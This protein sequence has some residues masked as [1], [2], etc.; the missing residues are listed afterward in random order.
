MSGFRLV[1]SNSEANDIENWDYTTISVSYGDLLEMD[2]GATLAT[3]GDSSTEA[4]QR[5]G[6]VV[7]DPYISG[8]SSSAVAV[9]PVN[10]QQIWE[11]E[12]ANNSD[13][14]H[15][16]DGMALTDTNTVNN[17]GTNSNAA[18][19]VCV[20]VGPSG[21]AADKKILVRFYDATGSTAQSF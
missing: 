18:T 17:S 16:G 5:M 9:I 6:V 1:R 8:A 20:Q 14:A 11:A 21:V 15:N 3:V 12:S 10:P 19:A 4:W 7:G 2:T 13:A